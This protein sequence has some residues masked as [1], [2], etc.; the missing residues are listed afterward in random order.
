MIPYLKIQGAK[1]NNRVKEELINIITE[2]EYFIINN[3]GIFSEWYVGTTGDIKGRLYGYHNVKN[4]CTTVKIPCEL[5]RVIERY[6]IEERKT[7]GG[8]GG[9]DGNI[10]VYAYKKQNYTKERG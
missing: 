7:D 2:I 6:F 1:M 9:A 3:G 10:Y 4:T 5:A 8:N